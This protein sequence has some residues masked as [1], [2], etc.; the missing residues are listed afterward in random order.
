MR[1]LALEAEKA[2]KA[3]FSAFLLRIVGVFQFIGASWLAYA[4]TASLRDSLGSFGMLFGIVFATTL[5][6]S[7]SLTSFVIAR[8]VDDIHAIRWNTDGFGVEY[9]K[10]DLRSLTVAVNKLTTN[11]QAIKDHSHDP[12]EADAHKETEEYNP[13]ND[14]FDDFEE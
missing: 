11:I 6:L 10:D 9:D 2:G 3:P 8:I 4:L 1:I 14:P 5:G 7:A 12:D 13:D